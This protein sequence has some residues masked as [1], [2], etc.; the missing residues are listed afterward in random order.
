MPATRPRA[1]GEEE[2]AEDENRRKKLRKKAEEAAETIINA[3][4]TLV[5]LALWAAENGIRATETEAV[6]DRDRLVEVLAEKTFKN[7]YK[8]YAA[9]FFTLDNISGNVNIEVHNEAVIQFYRGIT[10]QA[11]IVARIKED[12]PLY[13]YP[14]GDMQSILFFL[15]NPEIEA[16]AAKTLQTVEITPEAATRLHDLQTIVASLPKDLSDIYIEAYE[17]DV[18]FDVTSLI[19]FANLKAFTGI[20]ADM[21]EYDVV[22]YHISLRV[23]NENVHYTLSWENKLNSLRLLIEN[24]VPEE[25]I[26]TLKKTAEKIKDA[27]LR[28]YLIVKTLRKLQEIDS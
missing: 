2:E 20:E 3:S 21:P 12:F 10:P 22:N 26:T 5:D 9:T 6:E 23:G 17:P 15:L 1:G 8:V 25:E 18:E 16:E 24:F 7:V 4:S 19:A 27:T 28:T 13:T 14:P 11:P